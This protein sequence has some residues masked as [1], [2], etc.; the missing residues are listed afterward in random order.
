MNHPG[1]A[2]DSTITPATRSR[3]LAD[4]LSRYRTWEDPCQDT[5]A[6]VLAGGRGSRLQPL[7]SHCCKPAVSFGGVFR[8]I[9]FALS[10]CMNSGIRRI[11]VLS[12]YRQYSL[13]QHLHDAW[14]SL[15]RDQQEFIDAMPAQ[16]R[17]ESGWYNGTADAITQNIDLIQSITPRYTLIV[18]G[19][20]IYKADYRRM[21]QAHIDSGAGATICCCDVPRS[22]ASRFGVLAVDGKDF[23]TSFEE[24]PVQPAAIPGRPECSL[25]SMGVYVFNTE[26]LLNHL[27]RDCSDPDSSHDIGRD[28]IPA[29]LKRD[30]LYA[31]QFQARQEERYW[32]DVGTVDAYHE[33]S[34]QLLGSAPSLRLHDPEWPIR[35]AV[36]ASC[37]AQ[38]LS[39]SRGNSA[40]ASDCILAPGSVVRGS[41]IR[42]SILSSDVQVNEQCEIEGSILL[43]GAFIGRR[44]RIRNAIIDADTFLPDDSSVG[45]DRRQDARRHHVSERGITVVTNNSAGTMP[46][47][48]ESA[49][50][51]SAGFDTRAYDYSTMN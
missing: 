23:V 28:I 18:A 6:L 44:C 43:P 11:G 9:D 7:T 8:M 21:I 30:S 10:N 14:P 1:S 17:P 51:E 34:M 48:V 50:S 36:R 15:R 16:Q 2:S 42:Q 25:V 5:L 20:H 46:G 13:L 27:L 35:G 4:R 32:Q 3:L 39:D 12:Q 45:Y 24:K 40:E 41:R 47:L 49:R 38:L 22:E 29:L 19:D 37:P 26:V 33:A 31:Y